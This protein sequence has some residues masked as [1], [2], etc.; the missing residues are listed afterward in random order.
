MKKRSKAIRLITCIIIIS[1]VLLYFVYPKYDYDKRYVKEY[2]VGE[3]GIKGNVD[4]TKFDTN[5]AYQ[6]GANKE[7]YAVFKN[8][9]KAFSQMKKDFKKG[10][11]AI[12]KEYH[13]LPLTRWNF[14]NYETY[15]WQLTETENFESKVQARKLSSFLDIFENSIK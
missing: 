9:D 14:K 10:I 4:I 13:L 11:S 7:G 1:S 12:R 5:T 8:P 6:I 3:T 15:G 2:I